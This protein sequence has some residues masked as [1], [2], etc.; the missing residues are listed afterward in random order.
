MH[1]SGRLVVASITFR[2]IL[3][4]VCCVCECGYLRARLNILTGCDCVDIG[5]LQYLTD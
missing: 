4:C 1:C 5:K 3:Y 2:Y